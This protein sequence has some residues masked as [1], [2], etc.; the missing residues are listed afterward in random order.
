MKKIILISA[1]MLL[2]GL[3]ANSQNVTITSVNFPS[4]LTDTQSVH[5][6]VSCMFSAGSCPFQN[7]LQYTANDTA[8][9]IA[10]YQVGMLAVICDETETFDLGILPCTFHTFFFQAIVNGGCSNEP[11]IFSHEYQLHFCRNK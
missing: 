2:S 10:Y 8:Y 3:I 11:G 5:V 9:V 4:V 7:A 6:D 1:L